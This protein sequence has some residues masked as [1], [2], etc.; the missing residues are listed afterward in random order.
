MTDK[1]LA[2]FQEIIQ[3]ES[4]IHL[5]PAKKA[6]LIGRL[7]RRLRKLGLESFSAYCEI[8]LEGHAEERQQMLDC[9]CTNETRFFREQ[10]QFEF[11]EQKVFP[12]WREAAHAK[13]RSRRIRVWSAACSTGQEPCSLAMSLLSGFPPQS[14]WEIEILATDL[15]MRALTKAQQGIWPM[16]KPDEIPASYLKQFM[17]RGRRSQEGKI[18]ASRELRNVIRFQRLNLYA[19]S[20][21]I[22]EPFDVIFCRNVFIYFDVPAKIKVLQHLLQYLAPNGYLFMGHAES[23]LHLS[24]KVQCIAPSVYVHSGG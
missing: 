24:K 4:G 3:R 12:E 15:S 16:P 10:Q 21:D 13:R 20:Y 1:E 11:L 19:E 23:L 8:L 5:P 18:A 2:T 22:L 6:L 14:G 7:S 17:L 9:V